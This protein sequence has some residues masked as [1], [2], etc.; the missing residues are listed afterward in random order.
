[1]ALAWML[2]GLG[3]WS[4][5]PPQWERTVVESLALQKRY[6][7]FDTVLL[8]QL[9]TVYYTGARLISILV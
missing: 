1:M 7:P 4:Q 6:G 5:L 3:M 8:S 9:V 2:H